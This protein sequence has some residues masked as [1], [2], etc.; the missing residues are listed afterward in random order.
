MPKVGLLCRTRAGLST[1][2]CGSSIRSPRRCGSPGTGD[3]APHRT[4]NDEGGPSN[5]ATQTRSG[6]V[7][8]LVCRFLLCS[9]STEVEPTEIEHETRDDEPLPCGLRA[10]HVPE[11]HAGQ[12]AFLWPEHGGVLIAAETT[13]IAFG[14]ALSPGSQN[15]ARG[16]RSPAKLTV[17][18]FEAAC[19]GHGT[20]IQSMASK[21]FRCKSPTAR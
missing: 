12:L 18:E 13:P 4:G 9:A 7:N 21:R 11:H 20:A 3:N 19:F 5:P 15:S 14:L 17:L 10:I 1:H 2:A 8:A 6:P 16:R